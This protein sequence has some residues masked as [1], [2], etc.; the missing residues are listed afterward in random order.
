VPYAS[1][2]KMLEYMYMGKAIIAPRSRNIEELVTNG[3]SALLFELEQPSSFID[4][5]KL[6]TTDPQLAQVLCANVVNEIKS[7]QLY[8]TEN[9]KKI[10]NIFEKLQGKNK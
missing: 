2:L 10:V 8:W 7:K 4:K 3:E 6:V 9:S 5:L 1:P